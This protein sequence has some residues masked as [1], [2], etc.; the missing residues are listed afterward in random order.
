MNIAVIGLGLIGGSFC[1]AISS[2]SGHCC[3]GMDTDKASIDAAL[4]D[5]VIKKSITA[6]ELFEMDMTIVCLHPY[7]A[8]EF[9]EENADKFRRGSI[10]I[11]SCGVKTEIV[12]RAQAV[13]AEKG[14]SFVG[15]HPMAGREFSGY[16]Y[17][18][19]NLFERASFILTPT[20]KTPESAVLAVKRLAEMTGFSNIVVTTP[21]EHDK[22]IAFTSQLAHIV[23]S[24]YIKS[25][26]LEGFSGF[27]AGSF[28][29]MTRVA[30]LNEDMWTSLFLLNREP[31]V[32]E[33]ATIIKKLDEYKSA[34]ESNDSGELKRLLKEGRILK[35]SI[36]S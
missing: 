26:T 8:M 33:I 20:E 3:F 24:A 9:I 34:I 27:S 7:S 15:C 5:G 30:K 22:I 10:V 13:L 28:L 32:E 17:S 35:E 36:K 11:D 1:K 4:S 18:L 6:G 16:A 14:V 29:D 23:S 25:P 12:S 2:K 21:K 31:L 19:N